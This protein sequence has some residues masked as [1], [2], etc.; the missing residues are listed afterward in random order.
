MDEQKAAL[1]GTY[2]KLRFLRKHIYVVTVA[3][4]LIPYNTRKMYVDRA[5]AD[6]VFA[7]QNP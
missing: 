7:E 5:K 1:M 4:E 3:D 6:L 2:T